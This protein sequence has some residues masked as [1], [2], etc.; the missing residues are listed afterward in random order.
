MSLLSQSGQIEI[1][2]MSGVEIIQTRSVEQSTDSRKKSLSLISLTDQHHL[3]IALF[4][5]HTISKFVR[6]TFYVLFSC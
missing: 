5:Y 6:G 4:I 1:V 2:P 3:P